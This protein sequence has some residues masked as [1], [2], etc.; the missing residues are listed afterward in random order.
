VSCRYWTTLFEDIDSAVLQLAACSSATVL[1]CTSC[2]FCYF[3][4]NCLQLMLLRNTAVYRYRGISVTVAAYRSYIIIIYYLLILFY[5]PWAT[6]YLPLWFRLLCRF[7][8]YYY[9]FRYGNRNQCSTVY[10][11]RLSDVMTS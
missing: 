9:A 1:I 11:L 3:C 6:K 5:T 4:I 7:L 10:L 2:Y 8:R